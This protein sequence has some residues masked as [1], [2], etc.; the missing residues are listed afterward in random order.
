MAVVQISRI[1]IRRG[2][3]NQGTGLPQLAS[4]EMAWAI[5]T[6]ELYIGNGAVS[7]GAPAVGNTKLLTENDLS[8]KGNLLALLQYVYKVNDPLIITGPDVNNPI[9]RS[10]QDR[11]DDR[12]S[13]IEFGAVGN[14]TIDDTAA[15]QRAINELFLN[16]N[17][18]AS[19]Q[20]ASGTSARIPL[21]IPAGIYLTKKPLYIPSYATLL[22]AGD[23]KTVIYYNP[24]STITGN[25]TNNN[26]TIVTT[27]ASTLMIGATITGTN[28]P[29]GALV[30]GA[31]AGVSLT[32]SPEA[33]G[34]ATGTTFTVTLSGPAVRFV[35]DTSSVGN[36]S[37]IGST[38]GTN[39][40][41]NIYI[42]GLTIHTP[43]GQ[44]PCLQ[45]DAVRDSLFENIKLEGDYDVQATPNSLATGI[46][47]NAVSSLVTC[48]NNIFK[49]IRFSKFYY[50][51]YAKQDILNNTFD[52]C[53]VNNAR[54]GFALGLTSDG[55][56]VGQV[57]GPRETAITNTKFYNVK[58]QG[59]FVNRG[60]GN[61]VK[62]CKFYNVGANGSGYTGVIYPE[63]FFNRRG[64]SAVENYSDRSILG[65]EI[66][67]LATAYV[68][69]LAGHGEYHSFSTSTVS[70]T[71]TVSPTFA[72]RLPSLTDFGGAPS[73]V[74][75]YSINYS[76]V[77]SNNSFSRRGTITISADITHARI[78]LTD[79]YDF[80]GIDPGNTISLLLN[81]KAS[82]LDQLGY[83]YLGSAGQL[84]ASIVVNYENNLAGDVGTLD[85][86]YTAIS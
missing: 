4:G 48:E 20:T 32:I 52:K 47:M 1:Q 70:I 55:T 57:Y 72:F 17:G 69:E 42:K 33:D 39:Q 14:G 22:G 84:P 7:E 66:G 25:T 80:A 63:I 81:F 46:Q 27:A 35:N 73:G 6:Q 44:N 74:I 85:Y 12:V 24:V 9:S 28:I 18:K 29:A 19:A 23:D 2:Q 77:S 51:V 71:A 3:A 49:N 53:T 62:G 76:Y 26:A 15:L 83:A 60:V 8:A 50:A 78:Q 16:S 5:D 75:T 59:V 13:T 54:Q 68:P 56:T 64:N 40:P 58:Q 21:E 67:S 43:T 38:L 36:P 65:T 45:L 11:M 10:I 86:S 79:E 41:R 61:N 34:T 30:T 37:S 31:S 82:Y